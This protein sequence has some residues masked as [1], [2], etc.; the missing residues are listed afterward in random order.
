MSGGSID[1]TGAI[2]SY[3]N[4]TQADIESGRA[5]VNSADSIGSFGSGSGHSD[6]ALLPEVQVKRSK[7]LSKHVSNVIHSYGTGALADN[8]G[9]S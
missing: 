7:G 2:P 1:K 6:D 9:P 3:Q 8:A 4:Q 5:R